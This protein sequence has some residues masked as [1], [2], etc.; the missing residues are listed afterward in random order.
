MKKNFKFHLIATIINIVLIIFLLKI[1]E[2]VIDEFIDDLFFIR[3]EENFYLIY[4]ISIFLFSWLATFTI[5][6]FKNYKKH[7]IVFLS[8]LLLF[9]FSL[10]VY[11]IFSNIKI[12]IE[13]YDGFFNYC[14][15]KSYY[16][17]FKEETLIASIII[18]VSIYISQ[19]VIGKKL[20]PKMYRNKI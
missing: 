4:L 17:L 14:L 18:S 5:Y 15:K 13:Y 8:S 3:A 1:H 9:I 6:K 2:Y 11:D 7:F 20:L 19:M 10:I 12:D 16:V